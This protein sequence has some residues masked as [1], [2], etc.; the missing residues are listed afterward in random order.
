MY[1]RHF[2]F[3]AL[4]LSLF[5]IFLAEFYLRDRVIGGVSV[6]G[7]TVSG[8]SRSSVDGLVSRKSQDFLDG[9]IVFRIK[10]RDI[11]VSAKTLGI[12]IDS[13]ETAKKV[14][15]FGRSGNFGPDTLAR[16][17][18]LFVKHEIKPVVRVDFSALSGKVDE[19]SAGDT[20][21]AK[22]ATIVFDREPK[23]VDEQQSVWVD[24]TRLSQDLRARIESLSQEPIEITTTTDLPLVKR[25]KTEKALD[26]VKLLNNQR[27]VLVFGF[28]TWKLSGNTLLSI[29]RFYPKGM[30]KGYASKFQAGDSDFVVKKI[31]SDANLELDVSVD[32]SY[33]RK[34]VGD[35][36]ASIDQNKVDA[37]LVFDGERVREFTP[38]ADGQKLDFDMTF[39]LIR[40][41]VSVDNPSSERDL[42]I[43]L[44]VRVVP[45]KIANEEINSLGIKEQ[46]GKGVSYFAGSIPNRVY[47]VGLGASRINGTIVKSGETFSFNKT[48]GE[49]SGATGYKQAYVISSGRTVLDDG[50]GI[51]QVS[52]TVFRAALNAGLPIVTR[53]A[54]AYR[55]GY[56][57]QHG[58]KPG[59]DATV[60]SPAVDLAFKN[61]TD[62]SILVQTALDSTNLKLEV[63]IYG[64][65]DG[66]RVEISDPVVTNIKPAPEDRYQDDPTLPAGVKKQVDFA[67]QGATSV[68]SR[69]VF[70]G[71]K[72]LIDEAFKSVFRP[73][74]AV[75]LVGTGG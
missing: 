66:R 63:S 11:S 37:T 21:A 68:F 56:Y 29:L 14:Y 47:N 61:D 39:E 20:K 35:I 59:M 33:I 24:K 19:I 23:V 4:I 60:W 9:D 22:S 18:A 69:K 55:V 31:G 26:R 51:C 42:T 73:W 50:G 67:A 2:F 10:N 6:F 53:T 57:E 65:S 45:A 17:N 46:I 32:D 58:F 49:V 40:R 30:E 52:T 28:N 5:L 44:P 12:S 3:S 8:M 7:E 48:V 34:F 38:A 74:Q 62:H 43:N 72:V 64:T 25:E 15:Q 1:V 75:F 41:A 71:D 36:A 13:G 27:I 16:I 54:H 70:K